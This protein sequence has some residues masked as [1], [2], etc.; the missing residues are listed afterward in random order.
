MG[1]EGYQSNK[2][3]CQWPL[4]ESFACAIFG[5]L[6]LLQSNATNFSPPEIHLPMEWHPMSGWPHYTDGELEL[7]SVSENGAEFEAPRDTAIGE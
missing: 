6:H 5:P 4:F 1:S 2:A 7:I 3:A